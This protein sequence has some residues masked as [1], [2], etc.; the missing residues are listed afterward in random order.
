M[1]TPHWSAQQRL[2]GR[3]SALSGLLRRRCRFSII[4]PRSGVKHHI[5]GLTR[6]RAY[7]F[8]EGEYDFTTAGGPDDAKERGQS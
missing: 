4:A 3:R 1:N 6:K 8:M 5:Q 2:T 7:D